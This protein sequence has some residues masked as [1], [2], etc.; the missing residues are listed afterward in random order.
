MGVY[1]GATG[2][3]GGGSECPHD[4]ASVATELMKSAG[5]ITVVAA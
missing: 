1:G 4:S 5:L 2:N 3:S